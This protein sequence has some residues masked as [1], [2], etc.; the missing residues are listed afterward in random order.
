MCPHNLCFEEK[1]QT[2]CTENF[3]F[4]QLRKICTLIKWACFCNVCCQTVTQ[5]I[6]LTSLHLI[7]SATFIVDKTV[8]PN[9]QDLCFVRNER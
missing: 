4:L 1:Y 8:F 9:I 3:Q 7:D 5:R 2:F 6:G